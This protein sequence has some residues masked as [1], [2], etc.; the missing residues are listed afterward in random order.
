M[1]KKRP[2]SRKL[3]RQKVGPVDKR[4]RPR[5]LTKAIRA[6]IDA[7]VHDRSTRAVACEKAGISE[8]A[9]Y[10]ALQ[11][12]EV[13]AHW[14]REIEVLR[15]AERPHNIFAL[16]DVRDGKEHKNPM[17]R[18]AAAKALE[19]IDDATRP[20]L[21]DPR[22]SPGITI[23]IINPPASQPP[24]VDITPHRAPIEHEPAA[25]VFRKPR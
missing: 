18:V 4:R 5:G 22:S 19:G 14:K 8:R 1:T 6:T 13:A 23:R 7:I 9:L 25:P 12:P 3:V 2:T 15:E 17:A 16:V 10:L 24:M 11:K 20:G 21:G